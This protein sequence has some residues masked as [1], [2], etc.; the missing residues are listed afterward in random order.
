MLKDHFLAFDAHLRTTA[1]SFYTSDKFIER[2][3]RCDQMAIFAVV[4]QQTSAGSIEVQIE[5]SG[6]SISWVSK[7]TSPEV[8]GSVAATGIVPAWGYDTGETPTL[9][10]AR[11]RIKVT[12]MHAN[13]KVW[14]ASR[15]MQ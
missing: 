3:S 1:E 4:D 9:N 8:S 6:D 14:V 13:V 10:F 5:H 11:L 2:L 12:G 7:A 15:D